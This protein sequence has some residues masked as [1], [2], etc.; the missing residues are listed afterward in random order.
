RTER[1]R[2]GL[3]TGQRAGAA[4]PAARAPA[5]SRP[6]AA[7]AARGVSARRR[8]AGYDACWGEAPGLRLYL[9]LRS[10]L[11]GGHQPRW[12]I[13]GRRRQAGGSVGVERGREDSAPALASPHRHYPG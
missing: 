4:A 13:L 10:H 5:W 12:A 1:L 3:R 11:G 8:D 2:P 9:D 6:V 7:V